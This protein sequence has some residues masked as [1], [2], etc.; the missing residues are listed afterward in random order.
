MS[1]LIAE[2]RREIQ[3]EGMSL[4]SAGELRERSAPTV[5]E[6]GFFFFFFYRLGSGR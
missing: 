5:S 1:Y 3:F 2:K 4:E 6:S